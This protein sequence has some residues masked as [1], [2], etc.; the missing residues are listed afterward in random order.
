MAVVLPAADM[1][2]GPYLDDAGF[3]ASAFCT[4]CFSVF[5][6]FHNAICGSLRFLGFCMLLRI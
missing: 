6:Y 2:G 5:G 4:D 1:P 3:I